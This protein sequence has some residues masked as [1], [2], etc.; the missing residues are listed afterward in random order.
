MVL[1]K[2]PGKGLSASGELQ[3]GGNRDSPETGFFLGA[4]RQPQSWRFSGNGASRE[5]SL[6]AAGFPHEFSLLAGF[7]HGCQ[8]LVSRL[9]QNRGTGRAFPRNT[10]EL[11][12]LAQVEPHLFFF[13]FK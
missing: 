2:R 8:P 6:L 13:F 4:G 3:V 12:V 9:P 7:P 5:F 1:G 10:A 11:A